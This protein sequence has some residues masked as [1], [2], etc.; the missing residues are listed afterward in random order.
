MT[1]PTLQGLLTTGEQGLQVSAEVWR[2]GP[3]SLLAAA[4]LAVTGNLK[5][6]L[7]LFLPLN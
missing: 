3:T 1:T 2:P 7:S 4:N 5:E 6:P